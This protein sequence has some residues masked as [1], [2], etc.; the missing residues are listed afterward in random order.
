M[1]IKRP[2]VR[3]IFLDHTNMT[4]DAYS[5]LVLDLYIQKE[6]LCPVSCTVKTNVDF[7]KMKRLT[8]RTMYIFSSQITLVLQDAYFDLVFSPVYKKK[9]G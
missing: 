7:I 6:T 8:V 2:T 4:I 5:D 1:K 9:F 3:C